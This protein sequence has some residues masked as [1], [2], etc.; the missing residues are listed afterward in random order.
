MYHR[1]GFQIIWLAQWLVYGNIGP[2]AMPI[3]QISHVWQ[4]QVL[5][6]T[7]LCF[8]NQNLQVKLIYSETQ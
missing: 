7:C 4:K 1:R 2:M 3:A 6:Y 8:D 5:A